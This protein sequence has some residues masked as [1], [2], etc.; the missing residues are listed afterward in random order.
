MDMVFPAERTHFFQVSIKL[1]Q[2]FPAPELR[3]R[4]LRTR[5]FFWNVPICSDFSVFFRS[6]PPSMRSRQCQFSAISMVFTQILVLWSKRPPKEPQTPVSE[7]EVGC[8]T[9]NEVK[10]ADLPDRPLLEPKMRSR[11]W[12]GRFRKWPWIHLPTIV[13]PRCT[14]GYLQCG[15]RPCTWS[16]EVV[17]FAQEGEGSSLFA[18]CFYWFSRGWW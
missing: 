18:S 10:V 6:A 8:P 7:A 17:G 2:P 9:D 15:G 3:T 1:A 4:I 16:T 11:N 5:G 13:W 14:G 12:W